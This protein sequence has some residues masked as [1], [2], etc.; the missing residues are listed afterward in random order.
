MMAAQRSKP[1]KTRVRFLRDWSDERR[2]DPA[3]KL[4]RAGVIAD[5][6]TVIAECLVECEYA[7]LSER[8]KLSEVNR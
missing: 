2:R 3:D 6:D 5:V 8:G 4:Y 7:V 1:Q